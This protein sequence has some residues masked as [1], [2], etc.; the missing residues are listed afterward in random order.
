MPGLATARVDRARVA[1]AL[2][3]AR[4][5]HV[6][7]RRARS[8]IRLR[9]TRSRTGSPGLA[10]MIAA[11]PAAPGRRRSPRRATFDTHADAGGGAARAGCSSPPTRCSRSSATS[12]RA[13]SPTACS[14]YVWSE[15]GRRGAENASAGTDHGVGGIGFL[16]GTRVERPADRRASPASR[17]GLDSLGQPRCRRPTSARSTRRCSSSGST[18]TRTPILPGG[19][20]LP[21]AGAAQVRIAAA[22]LAA[23]V[24]SRRRG[25]GGAPVPARVQVTAK[26]FYFVLSRHSVTPGRRSSQL[27]NFGEDPHD[28]RLQR[29]GGTRVYT[30]PLVQPGEHYDLSLDA[31][32]GPLPALVQHREPPAARHGG[33]FGRQAR[34]GL[35]AAS[36][37]TP[38]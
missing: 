32:A 10:A 24:V 5:V 12:R 17:G 35:S 6:R 11:G 31:P 34:N 13:G 3:A 25:R 26:E 15:F 22:A 1:P 14:I 7:V 2:P 4:R 37:C 16:I 38:L 21:A 23:L 30:T 29:V 28:L 27:V 9:P 20:A 36:A 33:N 18:P 19:A 8:P